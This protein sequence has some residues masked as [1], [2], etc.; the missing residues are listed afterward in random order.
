VA[1]GYQ[2]HPP[3]PERRALED[4]LKQKTIQR[5]RKVAEGGEEAIVGIIPPP[6]FPLGVP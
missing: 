2:E 3:K 5:N 4:L 1:L 6:T